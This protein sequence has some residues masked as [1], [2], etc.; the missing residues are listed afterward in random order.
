MEIHL[1]RYSVGDNDT[2]GLLYS[3]G[4]F[5]CYTLEDP[6]RDVKIKHITAIPDGRYRIKLRT[7]GGFHNRY[8][9]KFG[10]LHRG[11]LWL[12]DVPNYKYVLMHIG[13]TAKDSSGCILLG[14]GVVHNGGVRRKIQRSTQAYRRAYPILVA[15][16]L[17]GQE[18]WINVITIDSVGV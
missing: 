15:P 8:A 7:I 13:N 5:L 14:D 11:M 3:P 16:L 10:A 12:Q 2:L 6:V 9:K 17:A 18:L 1:I 4:K